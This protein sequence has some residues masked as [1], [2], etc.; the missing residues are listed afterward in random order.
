V[1]GGRWRRTEAGWVRREGER[2]GGRKEEIKEE[3]TGR[4][5]DTTI[6]ETWLDAPSVNSKY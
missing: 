5:M 6:F 1:K 2:S 4:R 3:I